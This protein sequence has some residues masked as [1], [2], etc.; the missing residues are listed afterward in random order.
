MGLYNDTSGDVDSTERWL[1]WIENGGAYDQTGEV[2]GLVPMSD[3]WVYAPIGGELSTSHDKE[4]Y[5]D[6]HML[7]DTLRLF[8][9]SHTSWVGPGSFVGIE[10]NSEYQI[11]LDQVNRSIG[12]RLRVSRVEALQNTNG[13]VRLSLTWE[14]SG[15]APFYFDWIPSL[16]ITGSDGSEEVLPLNIHI[17]NILPDS[18]VHVELNLD[19]VIQQATNYILYA[20]II[21]PQSGNAEID[22]AMDTPRDGNWFELIHLIG[23]KD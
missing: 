14:N 18:P 3:A 11:A 23:I 6:E 13:S 9:L 5:L 21:N 19:E 1:D 12:Y 22:L 16:K 20:G 17:Q 8:R 4:D 2:D 10:H 7:E 15:I